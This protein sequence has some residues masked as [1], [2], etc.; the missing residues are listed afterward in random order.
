VVLPKSTLIVTMAIA[1]V[2]CQAPQKEFEAT[3]DGFKQTLILSPEL[4]TTSDSVAE[5]TSWLTNQRDSAVKVHYLCSPHVT[6]EPGLFRNCGLECDPEIWGEELAP[7]DS[8][9]FFAYCA[10]DSAILAR[11]H[12][13]EFQAAVEP[14]LLLRTRLDVANCGP[15]GGWPVNW[16]RRLFHFWRRLAGQRA[17]E[18][19][20]QLRPKPEFTRIARSR[21]TINGVAIG[22][23][24]EAV[25]DSLGPPESQRV[26]TDSVVSLAYRGLHMVAVAGHVV[27]V[28]CFD[29]SCAT[30]DGITVGDPRSAVLD[31]YGLSYSRFRLLGD[32]TY[33]DESSKHWLE[34]SCYR[35]TVVRIGIYRIGN[36]RFWN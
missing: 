15:L 18:S 28:T 29:S 4:L 11:T 23:T 12:E 10:L 14:D 16:C 19:E 36:Y 9:A 7:G 34:F 27:L 35:D 25:Q 6:S 33:T 3:A 31:A 20:L 17:A 32:V 1:L 13:L 5:I 22:M 2:C 21:I 26:S 24:I 8:V 30:G